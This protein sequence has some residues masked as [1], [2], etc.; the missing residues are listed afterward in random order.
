MLVCAEVA[1]AEWQQW[2]AVAGNGVSSKKNIAMLSHEGK[3]V[4]VASS[5]MALL[6]TAGGRIYVRAEEHFY[7]ISSTL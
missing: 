3:R 2:R 1:V 6:A 7:A 4:S 5:F